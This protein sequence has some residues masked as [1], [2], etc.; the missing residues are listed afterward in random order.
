[1]NYRGREVEAR[2]A[3]LEKARSTAR[4]A[5]PCAISRDDTVHGELYYRAAEVDALMAQGQ[6]DLQG[7]IAHCRQLLRQSAEAL[8]TA[9]S[10][11]DN[12]VRQLLAA[13]A[14]LGAGPAGGVVTQTFE[15]VPL[16]KLQSLVD[17]GWRIDGLCIARTEE[18]DRVRRGAITAG[19]MVIWWNTEHPIG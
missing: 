2:L 6:P 11:N 5:A 18:N 9:S 12:L 3:E 16:R 17:R 8:G 1:M 19:G 10:A 4:V 13:S 15:G 7:A 14:P